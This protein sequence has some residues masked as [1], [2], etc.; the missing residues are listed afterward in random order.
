[1]SLDLVGHDLVE[2]T[3]VFGDPFKVV[4]LACSQDEVLPCLPQASRRSSIAGGVC[5]AFLPSLNLQRTS[6]TPRVA[7]VHRLT[8]RG[9]MSNPKRT[10]LAPGPQVQLLKLG[11]QSILRAP[12]I[13]PMSPGIVRSTH[14][15]DC[16]AIYSLPSRQWALSLLQ[17]P[18]TIYPSQR[19]HLQGRIGRLTLHGVAAK[20]S[21]PDSLP[22]SQS[23]HCSS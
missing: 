19:L 7:I 21:E 2:Y 1:M 10:A 6:W 8:F 23:V 20:A 12:M 4:A 16:I 22:T 18:H 17:R 9:M 5:A 14:L 11:Q 15:Q 3:Y 13:L